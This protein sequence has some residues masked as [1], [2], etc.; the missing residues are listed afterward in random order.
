MAVNEEFRAPVDPAYTRMTI[1]PPT[2]CLLASGGTP[3]GSSCQ[4]LRVRVRP[5]GP[6]P[7]YPGEHGPLPQ[8]APCDRSAFGQCVTPFPVDNPVQPGAQ[9]RWHSDVRQNTVG[10]VPLTGAA[11]S[12]S[13]YTRRTGPHAGA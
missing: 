7:A 12:V 5:R 8:A 4:C 10:V 6:L 2:A 3:S 9:T 11:L 13:P 1:R